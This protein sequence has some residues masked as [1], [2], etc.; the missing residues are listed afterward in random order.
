M[1]QEVPPTRTEDAKFP[2]PVDTQLLQ[3]LRCPLTHSKLRRD[4]DWLIA[5]VGGLAYPIRDGIPCMLIEE[6]RL[7]DGM[8]SLDALKEKLRLT[9]AS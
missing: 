3:L 5:E 1:K 7:P 6:A 9:A 8:P 2:L 4:G